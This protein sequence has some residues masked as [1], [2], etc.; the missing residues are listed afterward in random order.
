MPQSSGSSA[1][2]KMQH[3]N[4]GQELQLM[5]A[6]NI[7]IKKKYDLVDFDHGMHVGTIMLVW[8]DKLLIFWEFHKQKAFKVYVKTENIKWATVNS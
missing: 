5:L 8:F 2:Q 3:A 7:R 4:T 1:V 6:S